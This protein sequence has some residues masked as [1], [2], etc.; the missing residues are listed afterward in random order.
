MY[1]EP[2]PTVP[3]TPV[4]SATLYLHRIRSSSSSSSI[5]S[6]SSSS[7]FAHSPQGSSIDLNVQHLAL[8]DLLRKDIHRG[9]KVQSW[10]VYEAGELPTGI[11][12]YSHH[13]A[14]ARIDLDL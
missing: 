1:S 4:G 13:G 9:K 5:V 7:G 10:P 8:L 12:L 2:V 14:S 11:A 3:D 6:S